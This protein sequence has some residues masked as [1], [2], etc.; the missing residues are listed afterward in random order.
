MMWQ[1]LLQKPYE[2]YDL[3]TEQIEV[4]KDLSKQFIKNMASQVQNI[5]L[6]HLCNCHHI[7]IPGTDS[8]ALSQQWKSIRNMQ[9]IGTT[10]KQFVSKN[11]SLVK[12]IWKE[13]SS[14]N[15]VPAI[16][17]GNNHEQEAVISY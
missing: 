11:S 5:D 10:F 15:F 17:W 7:H 4:L 13:E 2:D 14:L 8:Q 16:K 3:E 12:E 6:D 9:I 1:R